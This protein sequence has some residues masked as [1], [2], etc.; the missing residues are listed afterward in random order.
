MH[1]ARDVPYHLKVSGVLAVWM[2][3]CLICQWLLDRPR[4]TGWSHYFWSGV[5]TLFLT[6][7]LAL[8]A[9]PLGPFLGSYLVLICA[10]GL[11]FQSRLVAF[12]T[13]AT[14]LA[15]ALLV[16]LRPSEAPPL[17]YALLFATSQLITGLIVGYQ[18]WRLSVL[19]DYYNDRPAR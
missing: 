17:H 2:G 3:V 13:G 7:L 9:P 14:M 6:G 16:L 18:V 1:S 10:S 11:F 12:T 5:D 4:T 15:Y 19:R 8:V